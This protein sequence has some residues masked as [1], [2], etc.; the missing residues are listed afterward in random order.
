MLPHIELLYPV[1]RTSVLMHI[2]HHYALFTTIRVQDYL[3]LVLPRPATTV[4]SD[5][6]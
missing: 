5:N 1:L 2:Y 6:K 4:A 3:S